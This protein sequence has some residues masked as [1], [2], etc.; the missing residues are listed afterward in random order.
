MSPTKQIIRQKIGKK[1][2]LYDPV[3][4]E[5]YTFNKV[6]KKIFELARSGTNERDIVKEIMKDYDVTQEDAEKDISSFLKILSKKK[7]LK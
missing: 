5:L 7:L 3:T 4:S 2:V 1:D 6:G